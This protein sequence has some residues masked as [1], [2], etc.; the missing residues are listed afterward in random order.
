MSENLRKFFKISAYRVMS[1]TRQKCWLM[2][3]RN[4]QKYKYNSKAKTYMCDLSR[5]NEK[6]T[7]AIKIAFQTKRVINFQLGQIWLQAS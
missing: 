2:D 7:D 5:L 4:L 6:E 1:L 3:H